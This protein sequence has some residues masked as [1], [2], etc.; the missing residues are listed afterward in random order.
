MKSRLKELHLQKV[1]IQVQLNYY[2]EVYVVQGGTTSFKT[3]KTFT[4]P[5]G[6]S[7][8]NVDFNFSFTGPG[9]YYTLVKVYNYYATE[10]LVQ[11]QG[12]NPDYVGGAPSIGSMNYTTTPLKIGSTETLS[13]IFSESTS[14]I[15]RSYYVK[16]YSVKNGT[17]YLKQVKA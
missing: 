16:I 13:V 14:Q 17:E 6:S 10:L 15:S 2:A 4:I 1:T 9:S 3:G 8:V 11:R 5:I 7:S 12:N